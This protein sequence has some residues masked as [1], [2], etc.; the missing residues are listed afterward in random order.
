MGLL[1]QREQYSGTVQSYSSSNN[2]VLKN[3]KW[4]KRVVVVID[5]D[6]DLSK[7]DSAT[8]T[9]QAE[10]PDHY[11]AAL[12]GQGKAKVSK[13]DYSS[14][15]NVPVHH[16]GK[17]GESVGDTRP[18]KKSFQSIKEREFDPQTYGAPKLSRNKPSRTDSDED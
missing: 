10:H 18:E 14:S 7:G 1:S 13:P 12:V 3:P 8:F 15:P 5:D 9:I 4:D 17:Y 6:T 11:Q 2:L 16:D